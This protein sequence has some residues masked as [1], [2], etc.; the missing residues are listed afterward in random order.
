[1]RIY[2]LAETSDKELALHASGGLDDAKWFKEE[3]LGELKIYD[4]VRKIIDKG[5]EL[6]R[7]NQN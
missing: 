3:E 2:F 5:L 1:M 6:L 4:D 7:S